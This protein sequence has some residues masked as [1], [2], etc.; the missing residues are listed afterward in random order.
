MAEGRG[1]KVRR[2]GVALQVRRVQG[3]MAEQVRMRVVPHEGR[4]P[5]RRMA[6]DRKERQETVNSGEAARGGRRK[7]TSG[8]GPPMNSHSACPHTT[9]I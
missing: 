3:G 4:Q 6:G 8:P 1:R 2:L 7:G 9:S 5:E